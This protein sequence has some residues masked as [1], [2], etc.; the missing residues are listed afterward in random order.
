MTY[1][2]RP[3][4]RI[5]G[6]SGLCFVASLG[7]TVAMGAPSVEVALWTTA[8]GLIASASRELTEIGK[9]SRK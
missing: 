2:T 1:D 8:I 9:R 7:G 3:I 6:N 4:A 5:L